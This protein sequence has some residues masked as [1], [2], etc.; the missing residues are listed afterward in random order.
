MSLL[1]ERV[2]LPI[3]A[4]VFGRLGG[5]AIWMKML[6][7][8]QLLVPVVVFVLC[9]VHFSLFRGL[10]S[11]VL[12]L[13]CRLIMGVHLGVDNLGVVRQ[14]GRLLDGKT[15]SR[16]AEL[17]KDGDLALSSGAGHGSYF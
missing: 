8:M 2:V 3:T 13:L 9:L 15:A 4:V 14:V 12:F 1:L 6:G 5:S 16:L 11:G 10:S 17:I 7:R